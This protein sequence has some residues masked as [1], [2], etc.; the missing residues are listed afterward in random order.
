MSANTSSSV[1][2]RID[3]TARDIDLLASEVLQDG[4][5]RKRLLNVLQCAVKR[6][7]SPAEVIWRLTMPV[8]P[9]LLSLSR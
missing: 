7:E 4:D 5:A 2:E 1:N 3:A 6:V 8:R 9:H